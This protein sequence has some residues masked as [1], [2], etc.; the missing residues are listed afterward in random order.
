MPASNVKLGYVL[1]SEEHPPLDLVRNAA[2]AEELGFDYVSISD[3]FHPW[4]DAQGQ[5]PFVWSV[6]GGVAQ[7]TKRINLITGVTCPTIRIHPA[8]IAQAAATSAALMPGR[9][10][11]GVGTGEA[12]NEHIT[13]DK[14]P[15]FETRAEMLEEAVEIIRE[16]WQGE[17]VNHE[18]FYFTVEN[19]RIYTLPD[20]APPIVVAASGPQAAE[21]AG[22]IGDGLICSSLDEEV[23]QGFEQAGGADAK[24]KPR[25]LQVSVCWAED[26]ATARQ[27]AYKIWP[28]AGLRGELSQIL[29]TPTHFE[30]A[31]Q[32]VSEEDVAKSVVCGPDPERHV[33]AIQ[34]A[35]D[36]GYDHIH[37]GQIG[38]DQEGF[39]RFYEREVLPR[40]DVRKAA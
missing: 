19:A 30:Q 39:F 28:N 4:I 33:K 12:L 32:M 40:L 17:N 20:E 18:G 23:V 26:E 2:R 22:R 14:W 7:A 25:Y 27:T 35:I 3:H 31:V 38:P 6:I 10:T 9:F 8:I 1:S 24:T 29:P 13:G 37:V 16:L 15:R 36:A 21:L 11:L 34:E 5:S